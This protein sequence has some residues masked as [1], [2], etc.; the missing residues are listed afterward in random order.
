MHARTHTRTQA[1]TYTHTHTH[2]CPH[3]RAITHTHAALSAMP[4]CTCSNPAFVTALQMPTAI[5]GHPFASSISSNT[6][7]RAFATSL[8]RLLYSVVFWSY[9]ASI[10][11]LCSSGCVGTGISSMAPLPRWAICYDQSTT[12]SWT[13][14]HRK[15]SV[16]ATVHTTHMMHSCV[17]CSKHGGTTP[18]R[19]DG[20]D[21]LCHTTHIDDILLL[22]DG[23]AG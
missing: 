3:A 20:A 11:A 6:P 4:Q 13:C 23:I 21:V 22:V 9:N 8:T 15:H 19:R 14:H 2:L 5:S 17:A 12:P 16:V 7:E 18:T 10:N 1:D